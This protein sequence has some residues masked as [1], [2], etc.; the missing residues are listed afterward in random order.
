MANMPYVTRDLFWVGDSKEQLS[1][2]PQSTKVQLGFALRQV[3]NGAT[4]DIAKP[5]TGFGGGVF[6]LG[7]AGRDN[8]YLVVY[9]TKL[10][11]GIFVLDAFV[12]KSK[13]GKRIPQQIQQR[14]RQRLKDARSYRVR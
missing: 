5:L 9:A 8:T 1:R 2:F 7:A 10:K 6:E 12:K 13:T 11:G 3:Q 14:I 4:P